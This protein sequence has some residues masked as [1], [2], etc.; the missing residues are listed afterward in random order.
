MSSRGESASIQTQRTMLQTYARDNNLHVIGEYV[1]DGWSGTNY[2]RPNFQRMIDDIEDGKI[3]CVVTK[4]DCVIIERKHMNR[5]TNI[6]YQRLIFQQQRVMSQ[7][8]QEKFFLMAVNVLFHLRLDE[9]L[10]VL[11]LGHKRGLRQ[12]LQRI[13]AVEWRLRLLVIE[14]Q[15]DCRHLCAMFLIVLKVTK[16]LPTG[17]FRYTKIRPVI[18]YEAF[19]TP[20]D[21]AGDFFNHGQA[22]FRHKRGPAICG[23]SESVFRQIQGILFQIVHTAEDE[24][25]LP[26]DIVFL[27][28]IDLVE[29]I[30]CLRFLQ[31]DEP[32]NRF[33]SLTDRLRRLS[34]CQPPLKFTA[35][36]GAL[37]KILHSCKP[38]IVI[39]I[40]P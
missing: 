2:D 40:Q 9:V 12:F 28:E 7:E 14:K 10:R 1:D 31:F 34:P 15:P 29:I 18:R 13:T 39:W 21:F 23:T 27:S 5:I 11:E 38:P 32:G 6:L 25:T 36:S 35:G 24:T 33:L 3:N 16:R 30:H 4:D 26:G 17:D 20:V 19:R 37:D 22:G 8:L